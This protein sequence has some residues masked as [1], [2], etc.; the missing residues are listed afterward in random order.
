MAEKHLKK[1]GLTRPEM[2]TPMARIFSLGRFW[3]AM[4]E[5]ITAQRRSTASSGSP[6]TRYCSSRL[7]T[8]C[9]LKLTAAMR[10]VSFRSSTPMK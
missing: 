1:W 9:A 2:L 8:L 4:N 7:A 6:D 5:R 3:R 10:T